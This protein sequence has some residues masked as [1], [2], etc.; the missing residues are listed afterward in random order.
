MSGKVV[1][2]ERA[3]PIPVVPTSSRCFV[4]Q[5]EVERLTAN[6]LG[7][8]KA[9]E[10]VSARGKCWVCSCGTTTEEGKLIKWAGEGCEK[11]DLSSSVLLVSNG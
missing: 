10:G 8:G 11:V 2:Q 7:R 3:T 9:V 5:E 4:D 1:R 6:C